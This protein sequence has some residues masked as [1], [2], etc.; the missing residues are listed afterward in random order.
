MR[1]VLVV[2]GKVDDV[3]GDKGQLDS[4]G[5]LNPKPKRQPASDTKVKAQR[6][7]EWKIGRGSL[8][9]GTLVLFSRGV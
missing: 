4:R 7:V 3:R 6:S 1:Q 5:S 8:D 2:Q 9:N